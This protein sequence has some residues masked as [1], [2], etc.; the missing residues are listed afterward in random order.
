M[1]TIRVFPR[2]TE[3]TPVDDMAFYDVP[4]LFIPPHDEVHI[5]CVFT[6]D[7]AR[8]EYLQRNWEG[9]TDKPVL[10]GGPAYGNSGGDFTPGLYVKP[11]VT[12]TSRGCPN[13]CGFCFVP[14]REGDL[15]ELEIQPG[16]I[17]NDNNFLACSKE[18]RR[19]VYD[20][21]K[22]QKTICFKGGL[23]AARLTDW[24]IEEMR[25][26]RIKEL[27][28]ACDTKERIDVLK[29]ACEKLYSAGYNQ[30]KI[31]CYVLIGDDMTENENRLRQVYEAGVLPF[32]QLY[33]P[34]IPIIYSREWKQFARTWS[35]PAAYKAHMKTL[36]VAQ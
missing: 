3:M 21:L 8:A 10:I 30:N 34:E 26:L 32:A 6:W 24:D 23:E 9:V 7:K 11:G 28:L 29:K 16:N 36:L 5:C 1:L 18:H 2:R 25:G 13:K 20:M 17:I 33:Q 14:K 12:F 15:R 27:W 4:G 22:T 19:K 31:R 35:R